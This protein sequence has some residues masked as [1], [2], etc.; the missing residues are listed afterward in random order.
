MMIR[1]GSWGETALWLSSALNKA[2]ALTE[3]GRLYGK[4]GSFVTAGRSL[5]A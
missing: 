1:L 5:V 3:C 4:S 2:A